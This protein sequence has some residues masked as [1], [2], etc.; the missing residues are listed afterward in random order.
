M[1]ILSHGFQGETVGP[2]TTAASMDSKSVDK[3]L[4]YFEQAPRVGFDKT[5]QDCEWLEMLLNLIV[6]E[7]V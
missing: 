3:I 4:W 1:Q 5:E 6:R 2:E 7:V